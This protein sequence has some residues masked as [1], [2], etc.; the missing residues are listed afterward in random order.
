M[1][2]MFLQNKVSFKYV[3]CCKCF[4]ACSGS[5]NHQICV[6][7]NTQSIRCHWPHSQLYPLCTRPLKNA[8]KQGTNF[9][10]PYQSL[11]ETHGQRR[12]HMNKN[13]VSRFYAWSIVAGCRFW[14]RWPQFPVCSQMGTVSATTSSY[15]DSCSLLCTFLLCV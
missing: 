11:L 2:I 13:H 12:E 15:R 5:F 9:V 14:V 10:V 4:E 1:S 3:L 7:P 6:L 8:K